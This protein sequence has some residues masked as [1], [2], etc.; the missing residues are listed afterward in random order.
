MHRWTRR[1]SYHAGLASLYRLSPAQQHDLDIHHI[2]QEKGDY[3]KAIER[4]R[5]CLAKEPDN[6]AARSVL[7]AALARTHD[8]DGALAALNDI[9]VGGR[10]EAKNYIERAFL[11]LRSGKIDDPA[12]A[13]APNDAPIIGTIMQALVRKEVGEP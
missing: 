5:Q 7:A 1:A 4:L 13:A 9:I 6:D 11:A 8:F 10:G 12:I 3:P 2:G